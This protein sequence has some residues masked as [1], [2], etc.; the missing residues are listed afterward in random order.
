MTDEQGI[1]AILEL[2]GL[3]GVKEE[4]EKAKKNWSIMPEEHRKQTE[5]MHKLICGGFKEESK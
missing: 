3:V 4:E 2:Q 5:F 1:Q